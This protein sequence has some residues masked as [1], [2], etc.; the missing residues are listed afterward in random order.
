MKS[1]P[2]LVV[3]LLLL[4]SIAIVSVGEEAG[5]YQQT[6]SR[7]FLDLNIIEEDQYIKLEM[8]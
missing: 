5:T 1:K 8:R 6:V 2:F 3:G 4:S 7:S